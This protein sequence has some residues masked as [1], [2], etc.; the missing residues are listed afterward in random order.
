MRKFYFVLPALAA[1]I[2][3][4]GAEAGALQ[5]L[6]PLKDAELEHLCGGF[7]LPNG[8]DL[9]I[10]ID[11]QVS[12]NGL[13]VAD[14]NFSLNGSTIT[15]ST[16]GVTHIQGANGSTDIQLSALGSTIITNTANNLSLNQVRTITV[17]MTN[18]SRQA[19]QS[20]SSLNLLQS[21]ALNGLKNGLH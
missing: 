2:F 14:A 9:N 7:T 1:L 13:S 12:I 16:S 19:L 10:G 20:M 18:L 4:T 3:S 11:N 21:Q 15:A 5:G 8:I 6:T 17:D